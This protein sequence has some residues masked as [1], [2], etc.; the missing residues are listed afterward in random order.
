MKVD[1]YVLFKPAVEPSESFN[2]GT[3][4]NLLGPRAARLAMELII[5]IGDGVG[6]EQCVGTT[7]FNK[8]GISW[9]RD[10]AVYDHVGDMHALRA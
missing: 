3:Q 2:P 4:I 9:A 8:I 5:S 10:L 7:F 1:C 6:V